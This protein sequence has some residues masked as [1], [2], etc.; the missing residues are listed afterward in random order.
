LFVGAGG[1]MAPTVIAGGLW[2]ARTDQPR[3]VRLLCAAI[4]TVP[5]VAVGKLI[6]SDFGWSLH[7]FAGLLGAVVVYGAIVTI[8]FPTFA[9]RLD[10]RRWHSAVTVIG[11]A[12]LGLLS[13][14][15]AMGIEN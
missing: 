2:T 7:G 3:G 4:A 1:I 8:A 10:G 15:A 11:L 12:V 13:A 6:V 14:V 9:P 5:V